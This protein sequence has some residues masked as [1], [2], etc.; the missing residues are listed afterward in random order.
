MKRIITIA[1]ICLSVI[2][3]CAIFKN[4]YPHAGIRYASKVEFSDNDSTTLQIG[5]DI[6]KQIKYRLHK[7]AFGILIVWRDRYNTLVDRKRYEEGI[8]EIKIDYNGNNRIEITRNTIQDSIITTELLKRIQYFKLDKLDMSKGVLCLQF[9]FTL[10][11]SH[12]L[13]RI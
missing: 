1:L 8:I 4:F 11:L 9:E 7:A 2:S 12:E 6:S 10:N 5:N 13:K 3:G